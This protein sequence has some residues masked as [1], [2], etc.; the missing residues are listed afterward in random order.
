[1][2]LS[3]S[4]KF[5][6][7]TLV[8][9]A[10]LFTSHL[11]A[12]TNTMDP[13]TRQLAH[14]I[15]K[16]LIEINSTDSIGS[17]TAV[18]EAMRK[19]LLDAGFAPADAVI[20]GPNPRKGNLVA[21]LH[22]RPG[23]TLKPVLIICH[24][25]VVEAKRGDW[26]TDPFV[27]TEKDGF[28]YGR[29]TQDMKDSNAAMVMAFIRMK[30]ENYVPG[31]DLILALTADE[32]GGKSNGVDWLIKNHRDLIDAEFV[33]NPDAGG[34]TTKDGKPI[35]LGVEATEKLYGDYRVTATNPGG[36]SS[37][38]TRDNAIYHVADALSRLEKSP[39]PFELNEVTRAEVTTRA[40]LVHGQEADDIRAILKTP[41]DPAAIE[42]LSANP[43]YNATMRTT[44]VAT[45]MS[46]GHAPNALPGSA[47][48][49]VNCRILP[50]HSQ[51][52]VRQDLIRIFA[53]PSLKVGYTTDSGEVLGGGSDRVSAPPPPL[54][55]AVFKPLRETVQTMW[56]GLTILPEMETGASDSIYTMAAGMPS[57]GFNGMA[58]EEGDERAH[59]R[60]ERLGIDSYYAGVEFQYL[61]LKAMTK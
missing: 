10:T 61:Y 1:M 54:E 22:G 25:D 2:K 31:R 37:L 13:A 4:R 24:T 35:L 39:F 19:R 40:T 45:M 38:P 43:V 56:P 15:F 42:R 48:A 44:C 18:A 49:N 34:L 30:R 11:Q 6:K 29:G 47:Q 7:T 17:T 41:P 14:D 55:D 23:T 8:L 59:G 26:T 60:D 32:E 51:E 57:Y 53:D 12:Q 52:E 58:I 20:L 9:A 16:Q 5:S 33:I 46:A 28:F 36:H 3:T 27:F 50:G 21:R